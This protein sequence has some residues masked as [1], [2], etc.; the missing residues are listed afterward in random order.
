MLVSRSKDKLDLTE[1]EIKK[2]V[3]KDGE[4]AFEFSKPESDEEF[5]TLKKCVADGTG[6][7]DRAIELN[8]DSDSAWSYRASLFVQS[9]RVAEMEGN[10]EKQA[11]FKKKSEEA[12][13]KFEELAKARR[14]REEREAAEKAKELGGESAGEGDSEEKKS[15]ESSDEKK[16][17]DSDK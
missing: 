17:G 7:I 16:E 8:G 5:E 4:R 15:E 6:F 10:S 11:E 12:K 9:M 13:A 3:T 14:E 2:E 1:K